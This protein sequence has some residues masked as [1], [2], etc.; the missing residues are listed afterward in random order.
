MR[1]IQKITSICLA[2]V[3]ATLVACG[4][5][6]GGDDP[7]SS[8][9]NDP[10]DLDGN[11]TSDAADNSGASDGRDTNASAVDGSGSGDNSLTDD[12]EGTTTGPDVTTDDASDSSDEGADGT[13]TGTTSGSTSG[14]LDEGVSDTATGG[15]SDNLDDGAAGTATAGTSGNLDGGAADATTSGQS[16]GVTDGTIDD[17][18]GETSGGTTG[19]AADVDPV[20]SISPDSDLGLLLQAIKRTAAAPIVDLNQRLR[21]GEELSMQQND[22]LG[23]YDPAIGEALLAI[24]CEAPL[25]TGNPPVFVSSAGFN[26]TPECHMAMLNDDV[27]PCVLARSRLSIRT[28]FNNPSGQDLPQPE[29]GAE[30]SYRLEGSERLVLENNESSLTGTFYCEVDL[31]TGEP[32]TGTD[33]PSNCPN[34]LVRVREL[35]DSALPE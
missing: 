30:V 28:L 2:C 18:S 15:T 31:L 16:D 8:S 11:A 24:D 6:S 22:C 23:T 13:A 29:A 10:T 20:P 7:Q 21:G 35:L 12:D 5:S 32:A 3:V 4:S 25:A 9:F 33:R 19:G 14:N 34:E 26:D 27:E 17:G 1:P